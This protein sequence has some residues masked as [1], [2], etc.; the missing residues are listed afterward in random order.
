MWIFNELQLFGNYPPFTLNLTRCRKRDNVA[1]VT[2]VHKTN[3]C[4]SVRWHHNDSEL[5]VYLRILM[6]FWSFVVLGPVKHTLDQ[7][8]KENCRTD[9]EIT[10][11]A[12]I[13]SRGR[14][15][16]GVMMKETVVVKDLP[17]RRP[18]GR[19]IPAQTDIGG[20][21]SIQAFCWQEPDCQLGMCRAPDFALKTTGSFLQRARGDTGW[22]LVSCKEIIIK[23][24]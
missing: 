17:E 13:G 24:Y 7:V 21:I 23:L 3:A 22:L 6:R 9:N 19:L 15:W 1:G 12:N 20:K 16:V 4:T 11:E 18:L 5:K 2:L 14:R 10:R 8:Y